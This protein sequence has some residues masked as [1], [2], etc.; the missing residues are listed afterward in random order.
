MDPL[1]D[2][3]RRLKAFLEAHGIPYMVIGGIANSVWGQPRYTHD[4]DLKISLG[5]QSIH[6]FAALL[7]QHFRFRHSDGAAFAQ[8]AYVLMIDVTEEVP[9]DLSVGFLP[10]EIEAIARAVPVDMGDVTVPVC[11]AEDIIIHKA[12]SERE[13]DWIDIEGILARQRGQL[14]QEYVLSWLNQFAQTLERPEIVGRYQELRAA[15]DTDR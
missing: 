4:V 6:E 12:I 10:Y 15:I 11:T 3:L 1:V 5:K 2:A 9:A 13:K 7:S 8:R 14:D